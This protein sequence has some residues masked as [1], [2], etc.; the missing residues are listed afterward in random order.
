M[1][2][3]SASSRQQ[4][5]TCDAKLQELFNE[6]IKTYDCKILEGHRTKDLQNKAFKEGR[7]KVQWPN[8]KHN[9]LPSQ[10]V[11][12]APYP[13]SFANS[14][15]NLARFYHFAGYVKRIAE[16]KNIKLRWGG[17]WD[18]DDDFSD[19]KFND[20]PHFELVG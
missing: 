5:Q 17:D 7:S 15:S 12:V 19:Q 10:A 3:F 4:L 1:P 14:L 8:G 9:S 11:D 2:S 16:E 13:V 6:V 18:S 20:L